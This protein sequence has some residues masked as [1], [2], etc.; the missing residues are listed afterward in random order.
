MTGPA[1][2]WPR[3]Q[4]DAVRRCRT[5][6]RFRR[7]SKSTAECAF[8]EAIMNPDMERFLNLKNIPARLTGEQASWSLG[9]SP[10]EL[11]ILMAKGLLK[12]LGHPAHNGQK[13]FLAA[14]LQDL[15][16]D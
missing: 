3:F 12:P 5:R 1:T 11:P 4:S 15:R 13:F 8:K 7:R 6:R 2:L 10:H 9:F 16:R 14:T